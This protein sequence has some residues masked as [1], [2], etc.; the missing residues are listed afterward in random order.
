MLQYALDRDI[1]GEAWPTELVSDDGNK[2][3]SWHYFLI[4]NVAAALA[5]LNARASEAV[6]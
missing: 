5:D 1:D 6:R 4:E 2:T 3:R